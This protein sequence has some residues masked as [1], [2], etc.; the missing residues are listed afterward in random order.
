[1]VKGVVVE[2]TGGCTKIAMPPTT[3]TSKL[4]TMHAGRKR[5]P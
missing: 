2:V 3:T 5:H 4:H 1:V